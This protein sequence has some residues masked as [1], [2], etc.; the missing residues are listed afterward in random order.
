MRN[1]GIAV[2]N[3]SARRNGFV[4]GAF[5]SETGCPA[6][7]S[8]APVGE[9]GFPPVVKRCMIPHHNNIGII[10]KFGLQTQ[11]GCTIAENI[12]GIKPH[13]VFHGS[14][15]KGKVSSCREIIAPL[16]IKNLCAKGSG[17]LFCPIRTA[18]IDDDEFIC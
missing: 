6:Q 2:I 14:F 8:F 1:R 3:F 13:A 11:K 9:G 7:K 18:C 17:D 16:K 15:R 4:Y 5:P 10:R 12:V